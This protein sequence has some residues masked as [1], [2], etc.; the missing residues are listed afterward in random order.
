MRKI[1]LLFLISLLVSSCVY[2]VAYSNY[3]YTHLYPRGWNLISI[4]ALPNFDP[5]YP[6]TY[7]FNDHNFWA[8]PLHRYNLSTNNY[9]TYP[10]VNFS[11]NNNEGYW[12]Y[13]YKNDGCL[14]NYTG[15]SLGAANIYVNAGSWHIISVESTSYPPRIVSFDSIKF[16]RADVGI[17][18]Y[19]DAVARGL[20][21][22]LMIGYDNSRSSYFTTGT[23]SIADKHYLEPWQGYWFYSMV[24][25]ILLFNYPPSPP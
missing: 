2:A 24:D 14:A 16:T 13:C 10:Y 19:Q 20:I 9:E 22:D 6:P 17:I 1:F 23:S 25:G 18:S 11:V 21:Q 3:S 12:L 5:P 8:G 4:P 7:F 15:R